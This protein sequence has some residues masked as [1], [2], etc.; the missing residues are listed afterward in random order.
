MTHLSCSSWVNYFST[1][2]FSWLISKSWANR[3]PHAFLRWCNI[4]IIL[5]TCSMHGPHQRKCSSKPMWGLFTW[6]YEKQ[7]LEL[8]K[9]NKSIWFGGVPICPTVDHRAL[10]P[11]AFHGAALVGVC[12]MVPSLHIHLVK[13]GHLCCQLWLL[14]SFLPYSH[15]WELSTYALHL[16]QEYHF[17]FPLTTFPLVLSQASWTKLVFNNK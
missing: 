15:V 2:D 1:H 5:S 6:T 13:A 14:L 8:P 11:S 7:Q 10:M 17:P 3:Y 4:V 16:F 12:R 9:A